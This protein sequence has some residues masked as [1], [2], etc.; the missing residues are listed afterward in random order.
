MC[1]QMMENGPGEPRFSSV[2][3]ADEGET[4]VEASIAGE[5]DTPSNLSFVSH[6]VVNGENFVAIQN[7]DHHL[8]TGP[9]A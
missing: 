2:L 7:S 3:L 9:D 6:Q 4:D 1:S 8:K 5:S